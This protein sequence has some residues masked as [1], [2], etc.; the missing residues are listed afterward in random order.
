MKKKK[1]VVRTNDAFLLSQGRALSKFSSHVDALSVCLGYPYFRN[2]REFE[3]IDDRYAAWFPSLSVKGKDMTFGSGSEG[4][5][6][7]L[8]EDG[9]MILERACGPA[10]DPEEGSLDR[11]VFA[12]LDEKK[13]EFTFLGVYRPVEE[14]ENGGGGRQYRLVAKR[15]DLNTMEMAA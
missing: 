14:N 1:T 10:W 3:E 5:P 12:R 7:V 11:L 8:S 2:I 6:I 9:T 4:A 15:M 13:Y